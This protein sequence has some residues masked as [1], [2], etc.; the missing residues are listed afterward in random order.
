MTRRR[1]SF[2][3]A[4]ALGL[5]LV[6]TLMQA[7][8]PGAGTVSSTSSSANWQGGPFLVSNPADCLV[9]SGLPVPGCDRFDLTISPL[10]GPE[11]IDIAITPA[12]PGDDYD[13]YI[14]DAAGNQLDSSA[15]NGG[16]EQVTLSDPPAGTYRV[17]VQSFLVTP[18]S[19]YRGL[20]TQ[21]AV[22]EDEVAQAYHGTR[23]T[24]GF[25]GTP[26]HIRVRARRPASR[27]S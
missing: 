16:N 15:T 1:V 21:R 10:A 5:A 8:T 12:N 3:G 4:L 11:L 9:S 23:V 6:P 27:R 17:V 2:T 14:Y 22:A 19:T 25:V 26:V 7:A 13:L 24:R 18:G 20:A